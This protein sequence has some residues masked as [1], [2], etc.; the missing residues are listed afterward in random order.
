MNVEAKGFQSSSSTDCS[1][2]RTFFKL[3]KV[4]SVIFCV[5]LWP[6]ALLRCDNSM[7]STSIPDPSAAQRFYQAIFSNGFKIVNGCQ[8]L[9]A[10][11]LLSRRSRPPGAHAAANDHLRISQSAGL[12]RL[13]AVSASFCHETQRSSAWRRPCCQR[14]LQ[15][16]MMVTD[17]SWLCPHPLSL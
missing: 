13:T 6:P 8:H 2:N 15:M 17:Y 11:R 12:V 10:A 4:L 9:L 7:L 16:Q 14:T 3:S 1:R 5:S